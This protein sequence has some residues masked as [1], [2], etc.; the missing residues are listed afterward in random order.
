MKSSNWIAGLDELDRA[1]IVV[2]GGGPS[3]LAAALA[4]ARNGGNV[5]LLEQGSSLGGMAGAGMVPLLAATSDGHNLTAAG[6]GMEITGE[7]VRR[8]G[9]TEFNHE[10]Q[11]I[12]PEIV[13]QVGDEWVTAAGIKLYF[14]Q[15][16]AAVERN[17]RRIVSLAVAGPQGL[18]RIGGKVFV[19]ATGDAIVTALA[20]GEFEMGDADGTTMSP[21]LCVQYAGV[22]WPAYHAAV[23]QGRS[24]GIIWRE[25]LE[26]GLA[27]LPEYHFIGAFQTGPTTA[28]GNLG[29]IYGVNGI[30]EADLTR[31]YLEGRRIAVAIHE[32][33]VRYV[34]GF[35][36]SE[37]VSTAALLGLRET[38]RICGDYRLTRDDYCRRATFPDEI[39][40]YAY[41]I[42]IHASSTSPEDQQRVLQELAA[43]QYQPG[44]NYGI[45]YRTLL[46][47][48]LENLAVAG[49]SISCDRAMQS[50]L[51][52]MPACFLTGQAA[53]TA[54]AL[55]MPSHGVLRAVKPDTL[56][57]VLRQKLGAF[58]P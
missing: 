51:R 13:K 22:D 47:R 3:G 56:R 41:P 17:D 28:T 30:R 26:K 46:P 45:P 32:F 20:G 21:T 53:G 55:S 43:T 52:V 8:M 14:G 1:D 29:H 48:G 33:Y 6:I 42:D 23:K 50:S 54:A 9:V 15:K 44:E 37:L 10:W 5:L 7:V 36:H 2:A 39:G 57:A 38:R 35:Q 12:N 31:G 4:A 16:V 19:D 24:A 34:P 58:L 25:L 27:P 18:K 11:P 49:R 40:R